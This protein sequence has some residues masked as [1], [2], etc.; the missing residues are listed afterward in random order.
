MSSESYTYS[1]QNCSVCSFRDHLCRRPFFVYLNSPFRAST[2]N[3]LKVKMSCMVILGCNHILMQQ[4]HWAHKLVWGF[5]N[6]IIM[7]GENEC[8]QDSVVGKCAKDK[9]CLVQLGVFLSNITWIDKDCINSR[10]VLTI[11]S[12]FVDWFCPTNVRSRAP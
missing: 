6:G 8:L 1:E 2:Y 10:K 9:I 7:F 3:I 11:L 12:G 5:T 4:I